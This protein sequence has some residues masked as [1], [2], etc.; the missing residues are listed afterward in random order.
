MKRIDSVS[1]V[2]TPSERS[3]PRMVVDEYESDAVTTPSSPTSQLRYL[4]RVL[5]PCTACASNIPYGH[6]DCTTSLRN[7][8][9]HAEVSDPPLQCSNNVDSFDQRNSKQG[10]MQDQETPKVRML[11]RWSDMPQHLQFNPHIRSGYRPL[12]TVR[13]CLGS[14]FYIHNETI[15]IIT[16]GKFVI[17][18]PQ[19]TGCPLLDGRYPL[20]RQGCW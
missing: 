20:K 13:Q 15:N 4:L 16:H 11:R 19:S 5:P 3:E 12:M 18:S 7:E 1:L 10:R 6:S 14:L 9:H 2:T 8:K 17:P